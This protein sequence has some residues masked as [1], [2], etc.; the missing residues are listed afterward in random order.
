MRPTLTPRQGFLPSSSSWRT[1]AVEVARYFD[2]KLDTQSLAVSFPV[3]FRPQT[4]IG[5]RRDGALLH[6]EP[7]GSNPAPA[8]S[9]FRLPTPHGD[10]RVGALLH[11]A[12]PGSNPSGG[13]TSPPYR[14]VYRLIPIPDAAPTVFRSPF[15]IDVVV[16]E[17]ERS[18]ASRAGSPGSNPDG[19]NSA[20]V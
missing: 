8:P 1:D 15:H 9:A 20:V 17:L 12:S 18:F 4:I 5:G 11:Q 7:A 10:R 19:G 16:V 13:Q 6:L 3:S 2:P 14:S